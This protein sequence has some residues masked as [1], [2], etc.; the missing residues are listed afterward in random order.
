MR[1]SSWKAFALALPLLAAVALGGAG[2]AANVDPTS[3]RFHYGPPGNLPSGP[4]GADIYAMNANGSEQTNLTNT[5]FDEGYAA[6]SPDGTEIAYTQINT[7]PEI[8]V[9]NADGSNQRDL[10]NDPA[11]QDFDPAWSPDGTKIAFARAT[12]SSDFDIWVMDA[13]GTHQTQLTTEPAFDGFPN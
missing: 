6:W 11:T 10:S 2:R 5:P 8:F 7:D 13:D 12:E 3:A 4:G 9:M 1:Q